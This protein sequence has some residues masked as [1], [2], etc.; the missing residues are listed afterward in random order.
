MAAST[1]GPAGINADGSRISF[2]SDSSVWL[3]TCGSAVAADLAITKADAPDPVLVGDH[4]TYTLTV[5][6]HGPADAT[7][8]SLTDTLPAQRRLRVRFPWRPHVQ[9][10]GRHGHL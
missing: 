7:D 8:V 5:T 6:N 3:A 2:A 10:R 4:L 1:L 9:C